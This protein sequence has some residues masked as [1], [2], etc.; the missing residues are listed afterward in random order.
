[1]QLMVIPDSRAVA[2]PFGV[3][4]LVATENTQTTIYPRSQ[5]GAY[6]GLL[7]PLGRPPRRPFSSIVPG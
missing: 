2:T 7:P 5:A 1:V 6:T 4:G 3:R